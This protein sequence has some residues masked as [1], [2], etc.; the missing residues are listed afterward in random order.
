MHETYIF[1]G[2]S[3]QHLL[4]STI[5]GGKEGGKNFFGSFLRKN[6]VKSLLQNVLH[7]YTSENARTYSYIACSC[8]NKYSVHPA[9]QLR[10]WN[11]EYGW[12][13]KQLENC[14]LGGG[15]GLGSCHD[16]F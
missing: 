3:Q 2:L 9:C 8:I 5:E 16:Y 15:K 14:Y 6:E 4:R 12:V 1:I 11:A 7:E 10:T 13:E